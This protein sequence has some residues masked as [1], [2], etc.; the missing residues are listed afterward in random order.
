MR[1]P[2][3]MQQYLLNCFTPNLPSLRC[4]T[5]CLTLNSFRA[6]RG[7]AGISVSWA[8]WSSLPATDRSH[9]GGSRNCIS[10]KL[11]S[12]YLL[13]RCLWIPGRTAW[14]GFGLCTWKTKALSLQGL[15]DKLVLRQSLQKCVLFISCQNV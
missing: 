12:G 10:H 5:V 7:E 9:A 3:F 14:Q 13:L 6:E 2:Q 15:S 4:G 1:K 11:I 8:V